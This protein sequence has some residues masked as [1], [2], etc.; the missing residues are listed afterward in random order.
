MKKSRVKTCVDRQMKNL[1]GYQ[2]EK[3]KKEKSEEKEMSEEKRLSNV[4]GFL[5]PKGQSGSTN[6]K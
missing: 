4:Q 3:K 2:E 1:V 6:S 5:L